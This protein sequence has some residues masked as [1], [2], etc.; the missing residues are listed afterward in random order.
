MYSVCFA[1]VHYKRIS[2]KIVPIPNVRLPLKRKHW[3]CY[4][5]AA[6]V[7]LVE[8]SINASR[9]WS[10]SSLATSCIGISSVTAALLLLS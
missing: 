4:I 3:T 1:Y 8:R 10:R 9:S 6:L 2:T 7:L 5:P